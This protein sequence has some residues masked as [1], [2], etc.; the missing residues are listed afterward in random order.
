MEENKMADI[1]SI[2]GGISPSS[3]T[4]SVV[5]YLN[6]LIG[7]QGLHTVSFTV[8]DIPAE[9]LVYG[10]FDSPVVHNI[11]TLIEEA[12]GVI[13]ATPVYKAAYAGGLKALLDLLSRDVLA[14]KVVLPLAVGGTLSHL[15]SIDYALKPV[16]SALGARYI[17]GG[18]YLLDSSIEVV[19][20]G[21]IR[22]DEENNQRLKR[23]LHEF[24]TVIKQNQE[25]PVR[26]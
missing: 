12:S 5:R 24:I 10:R 22:V 4:S 2:S 15:L 3:R 18:V 17:L 19:S 26:T 23:S 13:I 1:I 21:T 7:H 6:T 25:V 16:L 20:D 9:D 8:R 11:S 14:N